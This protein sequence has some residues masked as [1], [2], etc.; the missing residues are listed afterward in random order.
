MTAFFICFH[1]ISRIFGFLYIIYPVKV[2]IS[3][4]CEFRALRNNQLKKLCKFY[5]YVYN[6]QIYTNHSRYFKNFFAA[7][8][9]LHKNL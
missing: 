8:F 3:K 9:L 2:F 7:V 1:K 4:A 5:A 6:L